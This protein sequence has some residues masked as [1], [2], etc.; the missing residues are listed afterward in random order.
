MVMN[1]EGDNI[2][3]AKPFLK[4]VGGKTQLLDK[5][6][7]YYPFAD[8][9]FT[10]YAEPFVGGGAVLFDV[11]N[12]YGGVLEAVYIGD[13]N[14]S[15]INAYICIRDN[16]NELIEMLGNMDVE[17]I[18][19]SSDEQK[20]VYLEKRSR[21]NELLSDDVY[22]VETAALL[23]FLNKTCFNG[24]YRV[25]SK[26]LFNVPMGSYKRPLICDRNN[27]CAVSQALQN[28]NIVCADYRDAVNFIDNKTF[29]YLD[30]PYRP[31]NKTSSFTTYT[32]DSFDDNE[33]I[34]LASFIN[35]IS[36]IGAKVLAS[37]SDP[38][39]ADAADDF[40]D[41]L[42]RQQDIARVEANRMIN[43]KASGRGA[44][45]ELLISNFVTT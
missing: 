32:K 4:W 15:L 8:G 19:K 43:S 33:Q 36:K 30:P 21:Y 2:S 16:C 3:A 23:I 12:R 7:P 31:L 11:L 22:N 28:V 17:F 37:N 14:R 18:N 13:A 10:K 42:Y 24:L 25:N 26:G 20:A 45:T 27:L 6:R 39:N 29:V 1:K 35:H 44:I 38:K 34:E 9:G 5:I 41:D 40:F